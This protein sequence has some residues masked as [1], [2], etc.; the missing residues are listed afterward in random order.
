[1]IPFTSG[2]R[3][4]VYSGIVDFRKGYNG[5]S[6][7]VKSNM[8]SNPFNGDIYIFFNKRNNQIRMLVYDSGGLVILSKRLEK[9]LLKIINLNHCTPKL[10]LHGHN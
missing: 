7:V 5:L 10:I 1:M 4:F 3:Y 2:H 9:V 8:E 6:G